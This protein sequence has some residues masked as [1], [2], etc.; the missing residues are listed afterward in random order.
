MV[1]VFQVFLLEAARLVRRDTNNTRTTKPFLARKTL[2]SY[3]FEINRNKMTN[4]GALRAPRINRGRCNDIFP[5]SRRWENACTRDNIYL[6][7]R[8]AENG[9]QWCPWSA[10]RAK[11]R[12]ISARFETMAR[13]KCRFHSSERRIAAGEKDLGDVSF[14]PACV[15]RAC[16]SVEDEQFTKSPR[17]ISNSIVTREPW[18]TFSRGISRSTRGSFDLEIR[19]FIFRKL[20][21][22]SSA[23]HDRSFLASTK[24]S[25]R[26]RLPSFNARGS[27]ALD[28]DGLMFS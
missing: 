23:E 22:S 10:L 26:T 21:A 16:E 13:Y 19:S 17:E 27:D 6:R 25:L 7:E 5:S 28:K 15:L 11:C 3:G 1:R 14:Q 9:T 4:N 18:E 20:M 12:S 2:L 8:G 24:R